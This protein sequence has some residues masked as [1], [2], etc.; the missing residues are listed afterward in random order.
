MATART[1]ANQTLPGSTAKRPGIAFWRAERIG[2]KLTMGFL[3]ILGLLA[4]SG[5]VA[6]VELAKVGANT[7]T[8]ENASSSAM[9]ASHLQMYAESSLIPVHDY[10]LT[11]DPSAKPQF[12]QI[13]SELDATVTQLG[14]QPISSSMPGMNMSQPSTSGMAGMNMGTVEPLPADQMVLLQ[15]FN[16]KWMTVHDGA[17]KIFNIPNPVGNTDAINQLKEMESAADSMSAYAQS[18]HEVQMGNVSQSQASANSTIVS[19]SWFLIAAVVGAFVLGMFLSRLI[20]RAISQPM[21]QL[22][23]ISSN[24]S[25]GDLDTKV[26]IKAGGEIGEL[27]GAIERMRTSLKMIFDR[28]SDEEEDLRSWTSQL[29]THQL[30]RKVRGGIISLGGR[31]YDVGRELD[32]QSVFIRLDYDLREIVITPQNGEP[33]RLPLNS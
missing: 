25:L 24:I 16:T 11:G 1:S 10:L 31:R 28:M 12:E 33:R 9:L 32:G 20:G 19:T 27:A 4:V 18:I 6:Y 8:M 17:E 23:Q 5:V 14:G 30:S 26:D 13:A 21:M 3:V 7:T 29:A 2:Q 15:N 22:T